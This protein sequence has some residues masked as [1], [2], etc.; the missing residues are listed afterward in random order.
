MFILQQNDCFVWHI[1][2]ANWPRY[3]IDIATGAP[4]LVLHSLLTEVPWPHWNYMWRKHFNRLII[5]LATNYNIPLDI[6]CPVSEAAFSSAVCMDT[7]FGLKCLYFTDVFCHTSLSKRK[8]SSYV[9]WS[10]DL[11]CWWSLCTQINSSESYHELS[12]G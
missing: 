10:M 9:R 11:I 12:P 8:K 5:F 6:Y 7:S 2:T 3:L 1:L 4:V